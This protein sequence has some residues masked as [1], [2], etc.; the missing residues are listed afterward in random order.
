MTPEGRVKARVDALLKKYGVYY[1]KPV[2]NGM[3]SPGLDYHC[4]IKGAAF[5]I[6]AKAPGKRPTP[7]Q[8]ETIKQMVRAGGVVWIIDGD[9]HDFYKFEAWLIAVTKLLERSKLD[10]PEIN[11]GYRDP[12]HE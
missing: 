11:A 8:E 4:C 5:F 7:R 6:E 12:E 2:Q 10:H 1:F 9:A 3:G